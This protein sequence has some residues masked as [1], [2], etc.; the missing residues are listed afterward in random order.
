LVYRWLE[1][2]AMLDVMSRI[3]QRI[4]HHFKRSVDNFFLN[5]I[6]LTYAWDPSIEG[7]L[8]PRPWL[9]MTMTLHNLDPT[10]PWPTFMLPRRLVLSGTSSF[11]MRSLKQ[12][13]I[14]LSLLV[15][16]YNVY[17]TVNWFKVIGIEK[18]DIWCGT[19]LWTL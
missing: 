14:P 17:K 2:H 19:I 9:Y 10:R 4:R 8:H 3:C 7:E 5:I 11:L 15:Y 18:H 6:F 1:A 16:Y 12:Q 13:N